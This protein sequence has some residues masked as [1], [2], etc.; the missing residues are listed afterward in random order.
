MNQ[1][2]RSQAGFEAVGVIVAV[3]LVA[4]V[5]L[6]GYKVITM[7][8]ASQDVAATSEQAAPEAIK[9]K[10]DLQQTEKALT[11]SEGQLDSSLNDAALDADLDSML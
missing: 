1:R 4:V 10:A 9:T 6:A 11:D 2:S 5:A 8:K 7:N 3:L